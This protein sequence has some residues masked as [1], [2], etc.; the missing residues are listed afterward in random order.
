[1]LERSDD[2]LNAKTFDAIAKLALAESGIVIAPE[3]SLMVFSRLKPRIKSLGLTSV[4]DYQKYVCSESGKAERPNLISALTTNV[5]SFFREPHHFETFV[6]QISKRTFSQNSAGARIWSAGSS[7]GQEPYSISETLNANLPQGTYEKSRVLATDIDTTVLQFA[8]TGIYDESMIDGVPSNK[9]ERVFDKPSGPVGDRRYRVK[10]S[11][12]DIVT[13]K[14]L[15]LLERWPMKNKFD[16]IF[17]RNVV[18]YFDGKTRDSLW[19]RFA[20]AIAPGGFFFL[21]HSERI[22]EPQRYGFKLCG[23]T[24]YQYKN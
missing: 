24:T 4:E 8:K 19:P 12:R 20:E 18:I 16:F 14:K 7:N 5:S 13:F 6:E 1:M 3:K 21:G 11:L 2:T 9:L 22:S 10:D 15:N 23:P 17:C